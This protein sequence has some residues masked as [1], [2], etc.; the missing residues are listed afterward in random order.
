[1]Q[2]YQAGF[3]NGKWAAQVMGDN[4][5]SF[6]FKIPKSIKDG[7]YLLRPEVLSLQVCY[8]TSQAIEA[9][10]NSEQFGKDP[11][12]AQLFMECHQLTITGGK[13]C[14]TPSG[15]YMAS[16]PGMLHSRCCARQQT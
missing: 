15:Q 1:V 12:G 16:F 2:I 6:T 14:A 8:V 11:G 5:S 7:H 4:N 3:E 9:K 13:G 10:L